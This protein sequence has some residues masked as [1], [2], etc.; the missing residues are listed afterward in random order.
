MK[1]TLAPS[2]AKNKK[3]NGVPRVVGDLTPFHMGEMEYILGNPDYH[4]ACQEA[5]HRMDGMPVD[6]IKQGT[7]ASEASFLQNQLNNNPNNSLNSAQQNPWG[8]AGE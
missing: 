6:V 3:N 1:M 2:L 4:K 5:M 8:A 7:E